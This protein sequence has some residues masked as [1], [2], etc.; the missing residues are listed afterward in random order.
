MNV[1]NKFKLLVRFIVA[2]KLTSP[3]STC[4]IAV[5]ESKYR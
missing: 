3:V 2:V 5:L 1:A 4:N